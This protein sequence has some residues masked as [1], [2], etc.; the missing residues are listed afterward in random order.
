MNLKLVV[1]DVDGCMTHGDITYDSNAN[2]LKTFNVKDGLAIV[3]LHKIGIKTAIITGR[4]SIIVENRA[5][6]LKIDFLFQGIKNK[7][8]K[9]NTILQ[10]EGFSYE[11]V[12]YIGDDINDVSIL[13]K[14]GYSFAPSD[15][16]QYAKKASKI[17]LTNKGGDGAVREMIDILMDKLC[18]KER[19]E[20]IWE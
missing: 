20:K 17:V 11:N 9:L 1:F 14:V 12:A 19:F 7:L 4:N 8:Q 15:A 10:N 3:T 6:E 18:L 2:E 13:K 5:K 16:T